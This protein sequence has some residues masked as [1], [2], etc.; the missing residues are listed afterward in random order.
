MLP[1]TSPFWLTV[2]ASVDPDEVPVDAKT[3]TYLLINQSLLLWSELASFISRW[4]FLL[5]AI[6]HLLICI[7]PISSVVLNRLTSPSTYSQGACRGLLWIFVFRGQIGFPDSHATKR[8][9]AAQ[10]KLMAH[11]VLGFERSGNKFHHCCAPEL[12][13]T[14]T[15]TQ[16]TCSLTVSLCH[17]TK[18]QQLV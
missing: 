8:L 9:M 17:Q 13:P 16:A 15:D 14:S 18:Y 1:I 4:T 7:Q 10:A 12:I 2:K 3:Y 5:K 6:C 11:R